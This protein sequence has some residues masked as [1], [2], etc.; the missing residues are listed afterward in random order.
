MRFS[1]VPLTSCLHYTG[2]SDRLQHLFFRHNAQIGD[3]SKVSVCATCTKQMFDCGRI[4]KCS[5]FRHIWLVPTNSA[6]ALKIYKEFTFFT[7]PTHCSRFIHKEF[8]KNLQSSHSVHISLQNS[9]IVYN[10]WLFYILHKN[11]GDIF[12]IFVQ[13]AQILGK[14]WLQFLPK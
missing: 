6:P 14:A 3:R 4:V 1:G 13:L 8:T 7:F 9:Q 2:R 5:H 10:S 11:R 12:R